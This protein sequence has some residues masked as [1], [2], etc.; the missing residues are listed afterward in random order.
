VATGSG[1]YFGFV[2]GGATPA[3][4]AAD[5]LTV[6]QNAGVFAAS[7]AAAVVEEVA[8]GWLAE[9]FGLSAR[10][11]V[12]FVTSGRMA[13]LTRPG[14][15]P[16]SS[17]AAGRLGCGNRR[18]DRGATDPSA[19][20]PGAARHHRPGGSSAWGP[21]LTEGYCVLAPRTLVWLVGRPGSRPRSA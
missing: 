13:G 6:A 17:V 9:L 10:V 15:G 18:A 3:A 5:W 21:P 11:S 14:R 8:G 20:R 7:P 12:G 1:R 19:G 2:I 16:T 4:V